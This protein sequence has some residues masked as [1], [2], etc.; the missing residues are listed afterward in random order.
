MAASWSPILVP[1]PVALMWHSQVLEAVIAGVVAV[2]AAAGQASIPVLAGMAF[3][4]GACEVVFV[5]A[6]GR[7][8]GARAR[9][10]RARRRRARRE[11]GGQAR[12]LAAPL[13]HGGARVIAV[14]TGTDSEQALL[15]EGADIV[16]P[17]L[18]DT[19]AVAK[20]VAGIAG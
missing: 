7:R 11:P 17:D 15:N 13:L 14:A 9:R 19:R 16:L 20:A 12:A 18:R 8:V 3:G 2:L 5:N 10:R 1:A 6:A 4:L